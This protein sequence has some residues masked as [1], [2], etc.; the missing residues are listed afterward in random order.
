MNQA[1][2]NGIAVLRKN[3]QGQFDF[4]GS[5][6]DPSYLKIE[7]S[8]CSNQLVK[9]KRHIE[10]E[11]EV[12]GL[13]DIC[14]AG[15][16]DKN[17]IDSKTGD[18]HLTGVAYENVWYH[19]VLSKIDTDRYSVADLV[20]QGEI[21]PDPQSSN[22]HAYFGN[23]E[24]IIPFLKSGKQ[25]YAVKMKRTPELGGQFKILEKIIWQ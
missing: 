19:T 5:S 7:N 24:L 22:C 16:F 8:G 15:D 12:F 3:V 17:Y 25:T 11:A 23:A 9:T 14:R 2:N 4:L 6:S 1:N 20:L 18:I 13:L 10:K 21:I